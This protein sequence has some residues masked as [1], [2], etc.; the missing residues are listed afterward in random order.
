MSDRIYSMIN[1]IPV[2]FF[3][4]LGNLPTGTGVTGR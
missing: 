4:Y 2:Y 3:I 1:D